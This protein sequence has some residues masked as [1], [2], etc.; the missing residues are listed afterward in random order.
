MAKDYYETLGVGRNATADEIKK[1]YRKLALK[2]HP[3]KN[4]GDKAAEEKFKEVSS[5][6]EVLSDPQKR[7]QYDQ[8]GHEAYTSAGGAGAGGAD[9]RHAQDIF[10]QFFG[11]SSG[12][13]FED[14]FGGSGGGQRRT[15]NGP[16]EGNDL[17][18]DL[19][20]DFEEAVYGADKA[21][22]LPRL[23]DCPDCHGSGC[24]AGSG[25]KRCSRCGGTGQQTVSQGFFSIRQPCPA[26]GGTGEII[27]KPCRKCHGQGRVQEKKTLKLHIQPGVDTGS[28]LRVAGKGEAGLRG[29]PP[30]D[31][32]VVIHVRP[33]AVFAREAE[34]LMC[35]VPID[36]ATAAAGGVVEVP[37]ISGKAK[38]RVPA[39][40]QSGSTLRLKGKGVPSLRG[41]GRGD[42]LVRVIVET[43]T[44][45]T[46]EQEELLNKFN[47]T[48]TARNRPRY[49]AFA[50]RAKNFL[51][52]DQP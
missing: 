38:M 31:L 13:S 42:L 7:S 39:G 10:S 2:Y 36:F 35:E 40:T 23:V 41:A 17:R 45:L 28:R 44:H 8:F 11:G 24:E 46:K 19:E 27:E 47:Q 15:Y 21:I 37:T 1:A 26:C 49:N 52:D 4:P 29:G 3:D 48:L 18:Y 16:Q 12:F 22:M 51:R 50:E 33:S 30:G 25:K 32:Y 20:I 43:P 34:D 5:A 14:L 6:Y 9:F